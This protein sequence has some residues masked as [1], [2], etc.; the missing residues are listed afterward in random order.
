MAVYIL[1]AVRYGVRSTLESHQCMLPRDDTQSS[2]VKTQRL[3][4]Y[5]CSDKNFQ[6][7]RLYRNEGQKT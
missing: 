3:Y 6:Q 1:I 2:E 4:A 5:L 7:G